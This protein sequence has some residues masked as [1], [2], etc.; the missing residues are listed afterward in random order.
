MKASPAMVAP[1]NPAMSE[2]SSAL[3]AA[4]DVLVGLGAAQPLRV[5]QVLAVEKELGPG[6]ARDGRVGVAV[7]GEPERLSVKVSRQVLDHLVAASVSVSSSADRLR[8]ARA[9]RRP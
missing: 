5:E 7:G 4:C 3:A 2:L 1:T 9:A 6:V 8:A